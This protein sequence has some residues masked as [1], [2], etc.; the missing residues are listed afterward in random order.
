[1]VVG[2]ALALG[3][4]TPLYYPLWRLVPGFAMFRAPARWLAL[5]VLGIAS[6]AGMGLDAWPYSAQA[7]WHPQGLRSRLTRL[8]QLVRRSRWRM[9]LC[10]IAGLAL[11]AIAAYQQWPHVKTLAGWAAAGVMTLSVLWLGRR[12]PRLGVASLM[13]LVLVELW[14]SG[15]ALPFAQATAPQA[16]GLRNAPAALLAATA[17]EPDAGRDRF[18]SMSDIRFDPGDLAELRDLQSDRLPPESVE[19]MVRST[20]QMEVIAPNLSLLLRLPAIDGYDGGMLPLGRYGRLQGLFL[21]PD[22]LLAD[23][24]LREQLRQIPAGRLLDLTGV[25]FIITDKQNDLWAGDVYY[26]LEQAAVLAPGETLTLNLAD[27]PV[28]SATGLGIVS[29]VTGTVPPDGTAIAEISVQGTPDQAVRFDLRTG[30]DTA[31]G[32]GAPGN[33]PIARAW[34]EQIGAE[35]HDYLA[36]LA[37]PQPLTPVTITLRVMPNSPAWLTVRGASLIDDLSGTH[38]SITISPRGDFRRIQSGDVKVYERMGAP[39]RAWLVHGVRPAAD[40]TAAL[41][42]LS[43]PAFDPRTAA[44]ITG[45]IAPRDAGAAA[46]V[47]KLTVRSFDAEQVVLHA[48]AT[49]PALLVLADADYPG[50]QATVDGVPVPILRANLMFRAVSVP[51]GTHDIV[52]AYRSAIW[53]LGMGI[54]LAMCILILGALGLSARSSRQ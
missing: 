24:R 50:W 35:G 52:F 17:N 53:R 14:L 23:G 15:R 13:A 39:G 45:S 32:P 10:V 31:V 38:A 18:L 21:P 43:D 51:A 16:L 34:P 28:F 44:I 36:R 12:R 1:M 6:L 11:L 19:L 37:F 9:I 4:Y 26:D 30:F 20:K 54:S 22:Q 46:E 29:Y 49:S 3:G 25:R 33:A 41:T 42:A 5:Y 27:Y 47:E 7:A 40:D 48:E 2:I 8:T